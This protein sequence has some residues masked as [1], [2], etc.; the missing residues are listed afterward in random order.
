M[1]D[2]D[3]KILA[4]L[5]KQH[6]LPWSESWHCDDNGYHSETIEDA[7]GEEVIGEYSRASEAV[8]RFLLALSVGQPATETE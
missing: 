1:A 2:I 8:H 3:Q 4:E 7:N 5:L 6:P